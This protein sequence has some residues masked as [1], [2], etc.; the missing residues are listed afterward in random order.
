MKLN[1]FLSW[2]MLAFMS[3]AVIH[4]FGEEV[5]PY[6]IPGSY[7]VVLKNGHRSVDVMG[8]HDIKARHVFSHALQGFAGEFSAERLEA[9]RQDPRVELIEPELELFSSA[10]TLSTGVKRIGATVSPMAKIDGLDER[11]N[12]DI[13]IL[14]T[15][16]AP[17]PDL[18]IYTN[19]SFIAGQTTDG[20]G[21]GTHVAGIAAAIDNGAGVVGV[22]PGARL[23]AIK[24]MDDTG[25]G[26][27]AS[28]IKGIDFV[29]QNAGQI[30]VA[31]LCFSGIGYS[32]ALRQAISNSVAKGIVFVVAAGNDSRDIY[33]PDGVQNTPDDSIPAAYPEVMTVSA[34][35]DLDGVP[36]S[37]DALASF[38]NYSRNVVA[39]SPVTSPGAAIDLAAPGVNIASTYL[40]SGY[41]TMSGTSM[42]AP[43]ASGAAALYIAAHS[44]ATNAAG[45]YAIRQALINSAQAQSAW[46]SADTKDPDGNREGL[47]YVASIAPTSGNPPTVTITAPTSGTTFLNSATITFAGRA[48]DPETGD[49][50]SGLIWTSSRDGQIGTGGTCSK[51]LSVGTH[52]LTASVTDPSG[53]T[54][55]ASIT[56]IVNSPTAS[57]TA[58]FY[59]PTAITIPDSGA[60]TP[61]PSAINVSGMSGTIS[62]V[63]VTL[64][65]MTHEWARDVDILLVSPTG[66]NVILMS[67]VGGGY[68]LNNVTLTVSDD[69]S[70]TF[71][72]PGQILS[73]TYQPRDYEPGD[74]F[75]APAPAGP[76]ATAM[77]A[78]NGQSPNGAW[79]L[80]VFDDGANDQGVITGGW[81]LTVTTTG[82][83]AAAPTISNIADP[84]TAVN[85]ATAAIPF[86]VDDADTAATSLVL[87][88][89]SSN[90]TLVP[91]ANIVFGGS[92][93]SR[94]VKVTPASGQ[95]GT[96][97]ITVKVS[98]GVLTASE[99]FVVT[100]VDSTPTLRIAVVTDKSTYVNGNRVNVTATVT[101]GS[102]R[103][104]GATAQLT[105]TT[106]TGRNINFSATTDSNG[107]AKFQYKISTS[108]D[109]KGTWTATVTGSKSGYSSDSGSATF[110]VQ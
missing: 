21:H 103:I 84:T 75:P 35:Y 51:S 80:Y 17:H 31:N 24:V 109:G 45:V 95:V 39:G 74:V 88:A 22:A 9:L 48:T 13:A 32:S 69:A 41:A 101:D 105:L 40:N 65:N 47:V 108:R 98:D 63:T 57:G 76:Y 70:A 15:G 12:A 93:S 33:G 14:D 4:A 106:A 81:G 64:R 19:V 59:S 72:A 49:C 8:R 91:A 34:L 37:D 99:T 38:S 25:A 18:N 87:T 28:V 82:S 89:S 107:T 92:G 68:A 58:S 85:T 6:A 86:T 71:P 16:I 94:T 30:E 54:G 46:G 29:T 52:T 42:A 5:Q 62:K 36:S 2:S 23:W 78:F 55:N 7:I 104:S 53:K 50:T 67:D 100:V 97:T 1:S 10:Q 43:H 83:A 27:T 61:Y 44:R 96:A 73:G 79:S 11:V 110:K 66:Q 77:S 60:A 3:A 90:P 56:V 20:N 26:T 102:N